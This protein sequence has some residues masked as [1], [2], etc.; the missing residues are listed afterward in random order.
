[1][2]PST[3]Q[4]LPLLV[5]IQ[6]R[7]FTWTPEEGLDPA[8]VST[9]ERWVWRAAF[10]M[11]R[12]GAI[13]GLSLDDLIQEGHLGA[14]EAARTWVPGRGSNFL[15]W[16]SWTVRARLQRACGRNTRPW[17]PEDAEEAPGGRLTL[18]AA[19]WGEPSLDALPT[20]VPD[21][22]Q[23][24]S[25]SELRRL[26]R[27]G[28]EALTDRQREVLELR[29]GLVGEAAMTLKEAGQVLG[30]GGECVRQLQNAAMKRLRAVLAQ[31]GVHA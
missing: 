30:C 16:A 6:G 11:R 8:A 20:H 22:H 13:V 18:L 14:L 15:S 17:D 9:V 5:T 12:I 23:V 29:F 25:S 4:P 1:M 21:P 2:E 28:M 7:T 26:V 27:E 19:G 24:A 31:K 3:A 10:R